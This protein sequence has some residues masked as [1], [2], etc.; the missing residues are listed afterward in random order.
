MGAQRREG[1]LS[2]NTCGGSFVEILL[3]Y[4]MNSENTLKMN[5]NNDDCHRNDI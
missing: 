2:D 5:N 1:R 4:V 3:L